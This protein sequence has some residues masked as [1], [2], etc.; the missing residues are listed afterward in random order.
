MTNVAQV[1]M[2]CVC[3]DLHPE[4]THYFSPVVV[5]RFENAPILTS[6]VFLSKHEERTYISS[7]S[8]S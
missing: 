7:V 6:V 2:M 1:G 8:K 5:V 3:E 4:G